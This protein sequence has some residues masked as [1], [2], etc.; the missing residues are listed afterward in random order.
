MNAIHDHPQATES[1][2]SLSLICHLNTNFR[3]P[4]MISR[5]PAHQAGVR[6]GFLRSANRAAHESLEP[7]WNSTVER[8]GHSEKLSAESLST[9]EG[10]QIDES[11][12]QK[13]NA[14]DSID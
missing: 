3:E 10:R 11:E 7:A 1:N 14:D 8:D 9:D 12:G 2:I 6:N 4:S 5:K 13:A